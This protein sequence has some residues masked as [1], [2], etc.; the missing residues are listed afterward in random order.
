MNYE[1]FCVAM[2]NIVR[3]NATP[4]WVCK[5]GHKYW[6]HEGSYQHSWT[7]RQCQKCGSNQQITG[8]FDAP[9]L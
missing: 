2:M 8:H 7:K 4:C 1:Q 6:M 3:Q 9:E 5:C